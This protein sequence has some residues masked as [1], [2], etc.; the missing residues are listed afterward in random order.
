MIVESAVFLAFLSAG[1]FC[2]NELARLA[3]SAS[4]GCGIDR[5][6]R[7]INWKPGDGMPSA[8]SC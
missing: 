6:E 4:I 7:I 8:W 2:V 3:G 1:V 5:V